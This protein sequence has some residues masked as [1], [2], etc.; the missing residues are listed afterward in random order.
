M[1][2]LPNDAKVTP[3]ASTRVFAL[4]YSSVH[5]AQAFIQQARR[6]E[7]PNEKISGLVREL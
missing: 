2:P 3:G 4:D 6:V 5:P 1:R 7:L